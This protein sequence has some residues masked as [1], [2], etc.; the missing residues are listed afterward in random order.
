MNIKDRE[1]LLLGA[2]TKRTYYV[3][4]R[5]CSRGNGLEHRQIPHSVGYLNPEG[6]E[7]GYYLLDSPFFPLCGFHIPCDKS[8][9]KDEPL[10]PDVD[11]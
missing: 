2:I 6:L 11:V 7:V 8:R 4:V 1:A 9:F 5:V 3:T 10:T